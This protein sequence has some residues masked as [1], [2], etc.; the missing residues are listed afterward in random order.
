MS[1]PTRHRMLPCTRRLRSSAG[2]VASHPS[3]SPR[4]GRRPP[5][6]RIEA[7]SR[8]PASGELSS[9]LASAARRPRRQAFPVRSSRCDQCAVSARNARTT[10]LNSMGLSRAIVCPARGIVTTRAAG[11]HAESSSTILEKRGDARSLRSTSVGA[12]TGAR[13]AHVKGGSYA[14]LGAIISRLNS[15]IC[16]MK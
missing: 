9:A 3:K 6:E 14:S 5:I 16:E 2:V 11:R 12:R 4:G 13:S 15:G 7:A 1:A 8:T 10:A